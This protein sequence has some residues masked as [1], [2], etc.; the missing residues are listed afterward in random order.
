VKLF[1]VGPVACYPM[2]LKAMGEQMYS[3]RS[4]EYIDLHYDTVKHLQNILETKNSIYLFS[5]TGTGFMEASVRNC[6]KKKVLVCVNG[7][8]GKRFVDVAKA[9]DKD[10]IL[11]EPPLGS[12]IASEMI[13]EKLETDPEIEAVAITH[14]ETSAGLI[15]PLEELSKTVKDYGK[16][17]FVDAVSSM[18]GTA[19]NVDKWGI[20]ICYSSSQKCFGVPPGLGVGS[21]SLNALEAS[22]EAK[23]KGWYFDLAIWEKYHKEGKGTPMTSTIPQVAGMNATLKFIDENGGKN[24]FYNLY[25]ERNKEIRNGLSDIGL[26]TYPQKGYES[27]TVNCINA[28]VEVKGV[29]VYRAMRDKGYELAQGYGALK[30]TTFRMGNMGYIEDGSIRTML[31]ALREVIDSL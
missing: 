21:V 20:D 12:P 2:V 26:S 8:F 3:H 23:N 17:L 4:K 11:I 13:S 1:T 22:K 16:L 9:N 7:S 28:P 14:N 19:I 25:K 15:N 10:V 30:E 5:S 31:T 24:W 6:V 27:P 29:T 18:G